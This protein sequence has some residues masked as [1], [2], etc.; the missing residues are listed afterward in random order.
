MHSP[1]MWSKTK[2]LE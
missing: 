1:Q 2:L